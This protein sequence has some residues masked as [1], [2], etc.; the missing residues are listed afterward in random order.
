MTA[1][2]PL[3]GTNLRV[4]N[5]LLDLTSG[6]RADVQFSDL[7]RSYPGTDPT[8]TVAAVQAALMFLKNERYVGTLTLFGVGGSG[9]PLLEARR[10]EDAARLAELEAAQEQE[11][12]AGV[13]ASV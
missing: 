6:D 10:A 11:T 9:V 8:P 12:S 5:R 13:G 2:K 4:F 1:L 3:T 7:V